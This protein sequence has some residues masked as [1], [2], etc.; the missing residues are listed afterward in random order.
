MVKHRPN[1]AEYLA[2]KLPRRGVVAALGR[3]VF[4]TGVTLATMRVL[5]GAPSAYAVS[6]S[7]T[8]TACGMTEC[9]CPICATC[10][11]CPGCS[12]TNPCTNPNPGACTS[13]GWCWTCCI[14]NCLYKACDWNCIT[15]SQNNCANCH[16]AAGC[17]VGTPLTCHY[18]PCYCK[19]KVIGPGGVCWSC[20]DPDDCTHCNS[21]T[22][23]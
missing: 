3:G 10:G 13:T 4:A 18:C 7:S 11:Q 16:Q 5:G 17:C 1:V 23:C 19:A 2:Q 15:A 9:N 12:S 8:C 20:T 22:S 6:C 14:N 21:T